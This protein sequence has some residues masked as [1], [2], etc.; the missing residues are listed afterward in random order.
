MTDYKEM[1]LIPGPTPVEDEVS[2][3]TYAHTN[4]R[5]KGVTEMVT[6]LITTQTTPLVYSQ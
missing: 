4:Q 5:D 1:L 2:G 6:P 3:E